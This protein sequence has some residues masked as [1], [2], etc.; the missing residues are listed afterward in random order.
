MFRPDPQDRPLWMGN[1]KQ[2]QL[3]SLSGSIDL[4]DNSSP[5]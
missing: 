2:F 3:I 4:G 5:R 1:L